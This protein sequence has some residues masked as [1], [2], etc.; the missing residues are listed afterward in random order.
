MGVIA[1]GFALPTLGGMVYD[2]VASMAPQSVVN[3]V[4]GTYTKPLTLAVTS[5][6]LIY[7]ASKYSGM[8]SNQ[9]ALMAATVSTFLF[10]ASAVKS[11]GLLD[12]IP[13]I[14]TSVANNIPSLNGIGG[15]YLGG[16]SGGYLGYLGAGH[17]DMGMHHNPG[18]NG[19]LYGDAA[20]GTDSA[21]LF[22]NVGAAPKVNIF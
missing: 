2:K 17:N 5:A 11:S 12:K 21:Q 20:A 19:M 22:G 9:T 3:A 7:L 10:A 15:G 13:Y 14:G 4:G 18:H 6:G 8:V 16:Y 1:L